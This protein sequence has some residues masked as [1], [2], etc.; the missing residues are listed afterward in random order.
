MALSKTRVKELRSLV[1][2]K[3]RAEQG[4]FL[5]EGVRMVQEAVDSDFAIV[6]ALHTEEFAESPAGKTLLPKLAA[7]AGHVQKV[8]PR[9]LAS[10]ADTV[11]AQGIIAVLRRKTF[12]IQ[13]LLKENETP[14]VL[15]AFDAVSD[16]G[17]LGSMI[18]TCDWFGVQGIF[19]GRNSVELWNPKVVR[20]TMGGIFHLPV[21]EDVDLLATT[22]HAKQLGYNIYVTDADGETHFDRVRFSQKA[23]II[24]GN[25]AWGVSDQLKEIADVRV[26][27]RRYGAAESLNVGVACGIVLSSLHRLYDE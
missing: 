3:Y 12:A 19:L 11:T 22:S 6:E 1:L 18:R 20:A 17:N 16:P 10:I 25:E 8:R 2:K 21:V 14:S 7:K 26:A 13:Q 4:R 23:L 27:I 15:V 9:D 5:I 24:F